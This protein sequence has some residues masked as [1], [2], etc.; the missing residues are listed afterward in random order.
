MWSEQIRSVEKPKMQ[1][2]K[3]KGKHSLGDLDLDYVKEMSYYQKSTYYKK[4]AETKTS[5]KKQ[6]PWIVLLN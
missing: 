3:V 5:L 2:A 1:K 4:S 6:V